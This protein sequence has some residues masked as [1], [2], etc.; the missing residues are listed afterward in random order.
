[1]G[2]KLESQGVQGG[3]FGQ[4]VVLSAIQMEQVGLPAFQWSDDGAGQLVGLEVVLGLQSVLGEASDEH[5][6]GRVEPAHAN[7]WRQCAKNG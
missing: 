2:K 7:G 5:T 1:M 4:R 3:G 6:A